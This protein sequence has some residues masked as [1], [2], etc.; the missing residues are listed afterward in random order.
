MAVRS[1]ILRAASGRFF[2]LHP[3]TSEQ[4]LVQPLLTSSLPAPSTAALSQWW[5]TSPHPRPSV[6]P[7]STILAK[8]SSLPLLLSTFLSFSPHWSLTELLL[9][10]GPPSQP[11]ASND[12]KESRVRSHY[13]WITKAQPFDEDREGRQSS[14]CCHPHKSRAAAFP[15]AC[16]PSSHY[17]SSSGGPFSQGSTP[18]RPTVLA[19]GT[20]R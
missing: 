5:L 10:L 9:P 20:P 2:Q 17:C 18:F 19:G 14:A 4:S 3:V 1:Q 15:R 8:P 13:P 11:L 6:L 7:I 12:R 16:A